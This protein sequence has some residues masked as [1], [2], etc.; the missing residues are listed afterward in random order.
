MWQPV[1]LQHQDGCN[2]PLQSGC[3]GCKACQGG[4]ATSC[5][6]SLH[7]AVVALAVMG[8]SFMVPS[9]ELPLSSHRLAQIIQ[10][11]LLTFGI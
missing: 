11:G 1:S 8:A 6:H 10:H 5:H 2:C 9:L 7:A 3:A 4:A